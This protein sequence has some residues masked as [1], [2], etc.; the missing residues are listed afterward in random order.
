MATH[1][2][3]LCNPTH[4]IIFYFTPK[5]C[6]WLNQIEI[7]FSILARKV[8]LR[9]NSLSVENLCHKIKKFI[10][11]FNETMAKPFRWTYQSKPLAA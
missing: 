7:S 1:Q 6:S 2:A 9:G 4:R 11:Y 8:I 10:A 5:H 3:F